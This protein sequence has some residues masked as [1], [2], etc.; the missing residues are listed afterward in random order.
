[1]SEHA[2]DKAWQRFRRLRLHVW[3]ASAGF[4]FSVPA[5]AL[6]HLGGRSGLPDFVPALAFW[7][8]GMVAIS[9]FK[10]F[11][12]PRCGKEFERRWPGQNRFPRGSCPHCGL[13]KFGHPGEL[14]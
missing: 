10:E 4:V 13:K 8:Y 5:V 3:I 9:R 6:L 12:C 7:L 1:M 14:A 2:Y 11:R